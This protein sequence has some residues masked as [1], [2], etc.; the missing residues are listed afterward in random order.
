MA[1]GI[2]VNR[3]QKEEHKSEILQIR[4]YFRRLVG[5]AQR[6]RERSW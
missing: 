4:H 3:D 5:F 2:A 6:L 1:Q